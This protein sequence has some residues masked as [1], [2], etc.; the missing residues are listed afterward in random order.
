ME[1]CVTQTAPEPPAWLVDPAAWAAEEAVA[2]GGGPVAKHFRAAE[3]APGVLFAEASS[4][5]AGVGT[6]EG[7]AVATETLYAFLLQVLGSE[8]ASPLRFWNFVPGITDPSGGTEPHRYMCFN[9]GRAAG[10]QAAGAEGA[11]VAASAVGVPRSQ[12]LTVQALAR[13]APATP[14]ENPRQVPAWRYSER[15]GP[16]PP[17]F[18]RAVRLPDD[19][20]LHPGAMLLSGTAAVVGEDSV[21]SGDLAAQAAET[22]TNLAALLGAAAGASRAEEDERLTGLR[23]LRVYVTREEDLAAVGELFRERCPGL[24]TLTLMH[25]PLCRPELLLEAEGVTVDRLRG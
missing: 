25:A 6:A 21:H 17:T 24:G 18:A 22:C 12:P 7:L 9:A 14:L 4:P 23:H 8:G 20:P 10:M 3:L 11:G 5:A 2:V 15:Y 1:D 19:A 13:P 16:T